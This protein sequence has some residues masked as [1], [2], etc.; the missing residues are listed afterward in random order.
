V[1]PIRIDR[2][3]LEAME[4]T[5]RLEALKQLELL[6]EIRAVDPLQF[7]HPHHKQHELM[8]VHQ[9]VRAFL[10]G[11]RSG[12]TTVGIA[13]DL[14]QAIDPEA[15]PE[16]LRQYKRWD[17]PFYCRIVTPDFTAT[18][19]G[20]VFQKL[21]EW[22]PRAQLVGDSWDK[23]YDKQNRLLRFKNGSWFQFMT[24][25]QDLDK[26]GGT[27]LHRCHYDEEP[28]EAIRK[29]CLMRLIDYGGEELFTMTP[30]LGMTWMFTEI[31]EPWEKGELEDGHVTTVDM[32]DNPY[33]DATTK[34]RVLGGLSRRSARP[35][36]R[37]ASSTSAVSSTAS[38]AARSTSAQR[39]EPQGME[40]T[41][42]SWPA[43]PS[44]SASTP[45]S[46]SWPLSSS[47]PSITRDA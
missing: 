18:M 20:V 15:V 42:T 13:D 17:P 1:K 3:V 5:E 29:E 32:D 40:T 24:Y 30:L 46:A 39:C 38:S 25:E 22:A 26:F 14:I 8:R 4:P 23:A 16:H 27:A 2:K 12:K 41:S 6:N 45:A 37:A 7:F 36:R 33:L 43:R 34:Q 19:E 44:T 35:V 9:P 10:G 28:P 47:A 11:N 21:R 31:W